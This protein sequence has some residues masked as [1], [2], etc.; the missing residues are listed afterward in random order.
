MSREKDI[1]E[2][3]DPSE[4]VSTSSPIAAGVGKGALNDEGPG[5]SGQFSTDTMGSTSSA[6]SGLS[7]PLSMET[8]LLSKPPL[9]PMRKV[10]RNGPKPSRAGRQAPAE[11]HP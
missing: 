6:S 5:R 3:L 9:P 1:P 10:F 7:Q 11:R 4:C 2:E 8:S